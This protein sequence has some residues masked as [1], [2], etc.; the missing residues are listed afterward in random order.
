MPYITI[1]MSQRDFQI[2]LVDL[3]LNENYDFGLMNRRQVNPTSTVTRYLNN[4]PERIAGTTNVLGMI[5]ELQTFNRTYAHLFSAPR[6]SLYRTFYLDKRGGGKRRIDAPEPD[7]MDAL[8]NLKKILEGF[9]ALY[10]TSAYAYIAN[11]N[12]LQCVKKHQANE[13]RWFLKL[14]FHDF[15]G[16]TTQDF[17]MKMFSIVYPFSSIMS[18]QDGRDALSRALSLCFLRGGLPQGTPISPFITNTM[19]I[20]IDHTLCNKLRSFGNARYIYTRYADDLLISSRSNFDFKAVQDEIV[21]VLRRANAPFELNV[22]KT[23]YGSRAGSN[24]NLGMMLNKDNQITIGWKNHE[25]FRH[26]INNYLFDR[27][28]GIKWE[29]SSLTHMNGLLSY[30]NMIEPEWVSHIIEVYE[31]KYQVN[32]KSCIKYDIKYSRG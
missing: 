18:Y 1:P 2:S 24:F 8:R 29:Y 25:A 5:G 32:L 13:S 21:D 7:L 20:P 16:S 3:F 27:M 10:H 23:R 11:R 6:Q 22:E 14:D 9:G 30:Y 4:V 31:R 12:T 17:V 26:M 19:M 28:R 15:F